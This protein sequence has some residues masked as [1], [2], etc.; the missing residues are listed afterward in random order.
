M[1]ASSGESAGR[2]GSP[3]GLV[4][5]LIRGRCVRVVQQRLRLALRVRAFLFDEH[6]LFRLARCPLESARVEREKQGDLVDADSDVA[7]ASF[8]DPQQLESA[9]HIRIGLARGRDQQTRRIGSEDDAVEAVGAC[10]GRARAA[11]CD[12]R[13]A[14][15]A[16]VSP[17]ASGRM[18]TPPAGPR[19]L[20]HQE[21]SGL[22]RND[23]G[24]S[25]RPSR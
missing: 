3:P 19:G 12:A 4:L 17:R 8:V 16:P 15:P 6:D 14:S 22:A 11:A 2:S 13:G 20:R 21:V 1:R 23:D 24:R 10:E 7:R 25:P 18:Q 5:P 9:Q